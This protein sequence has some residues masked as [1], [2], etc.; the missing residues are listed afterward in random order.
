MAFNVAAVVATALL[1]H[2]PQGPAVRSALVAAA[3]VPGLGYIAT[4]IRDIRRLDELQQRI[5][6]EAIA[7]AFAGTFLLTL[8]YPLLNRA[9]FVPD[10]SPVVVA[11]VMVVLATGSYW[12]AKRRYE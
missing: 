2:I 6:L 7:V 4:M 3:L 10:C 12:F 8:L 9:G 1:K 11:V 5:Y